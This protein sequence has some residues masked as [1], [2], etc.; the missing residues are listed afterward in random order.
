M[1]AKKLKAYEV[2]QKYGWVQHR[3]GN[4]RIGFCVVGALRHTGKWIRLSKKVGKVLGVPADPIMQGYVSDWNDQ[5][6]RTKRQVI[7]LLKK[8]EG[9]QP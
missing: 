2:I 7:A 4:I 1:K 3:Y 5:K 9:D 8:V 6:D